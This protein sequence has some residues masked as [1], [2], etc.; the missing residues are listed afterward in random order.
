VFAVGAEL[1]LAI[2]AFPV[3]A[4]DTVGAGDTFCGVLAAALDRDASLADGLRRATVAAALACSRGG[5]QPS[6]PAAAET[7]AA[8]ERDRRVLQS[9]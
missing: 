4:V 8:I 3:E 9:A 5:A 6:I 2:D 1:A 7:S